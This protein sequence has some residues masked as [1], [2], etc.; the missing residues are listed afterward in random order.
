MRLVV[1]S[2]EVQTIVSATPEG[3]SLN[4]VGRE[5]DDSLWKTF[6]RARHWKPAKLTRKSASLLSNA[7]R[8]PYVYAR[9]LTMPASGCSRAR[10]S[11]W[12]SQ[13]T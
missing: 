6:Q 2:G 13:S 1:T 5:T 11:I 12:K 9:Q 3:V 4:M 8:G 10:G 7:S